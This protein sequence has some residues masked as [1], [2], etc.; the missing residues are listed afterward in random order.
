[1]PQDPTASDAP[2]DVRFARPNTTGV[3]AGVKIIEGCRDERGI[4]RGLDVHWLEWGEAASP[5]MVLLHG[6]TGH[7]HTWDHVAPALARRYHVFAPDQRG[8]GDTSAAES[9]ATQD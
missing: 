1:M 6:L 2:V 4:V 7:A 9:Y 3:N 8:H 5:P